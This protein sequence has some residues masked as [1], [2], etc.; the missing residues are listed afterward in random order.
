MASAM[1]ERVGPQVA[2]LGLNNKDPLSQL[3]ISVHRKVEMKRTYVL[4]ILLILV[5]IGSMILDKKANEEP[6]ETR[7]W[8]RTTVRA[9]L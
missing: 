1:R 5:A 4:L 6:P 8:P 2:S 3:V 7:A 9:A